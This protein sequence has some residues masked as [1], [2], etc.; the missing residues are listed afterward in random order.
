MKAEGIPTFVQKS[1]IFPTIFQIRGDQL[2]IS[3]T[4]H[5]G[6]FDEQVIDLRT[7]DPNYQPLAVRLD[8]LVAIYGTIAV[9]SAA[10]VWGLWQLTS[11]VPF[12]PRETFLHFFL[13]PSLFFAIAF[14][15]SIQSS[16]RMEYYVFNNQWKKP[17]F[18]IICERSQRDECAAFIS[19]LVA[20]IELAQSGLPGDERARLLA[21]F[22]AE[23]P[24]PARPVFNT[25]W[26][27][28][29][30]FGA[31]ATGLPP[32]PGLVEAS[33][34]WAFPVVF[35]LCAWGLCLSV[36]SF[37]GKEPGRWWSL[38]GAALSLVPP[39]FY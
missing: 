3:I 24:L 13:W 2:A 8:R 15:Q 1:R 30:A 21:Q 18:R 16:R 20:R 11:Y 6:G 7:V 17:A 26:K 37:L 36:Y 39:F 14:A 28:S 4:R 9:L 38:L 35:V 22:E 5:S 29:I 19:I 25:R 27:W 32:I 31:L 10:V 34:G 12:V 33:G 23:T